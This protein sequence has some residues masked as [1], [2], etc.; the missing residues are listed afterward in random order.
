MRSQRSLLLVVAIT[1]G[2]GAVALFLLD[3]GSQGSIP[4]AAPDESGADSLDPAASASASAQRSRRLAAEP[5]LADNATSGTGAV[6]DVRS[7]AVTSSPLVRGVVSDGAGRPVPGATVRLVSLVPDG[8]R[9]IDFVTWADEQGRFSFVRQPFL[10]RMANEGGLGL[11][12]RGAFESA[13]TTPF[14]LGGD[15]VVTVAPVRTIVGRLRAS[16]GGAVYRLEVRC[17][18]AGEGSAGHHATVEVEEDG[19][20]ELTIPPGRWDLEVAQRFRNG[21][22]TIDR[23]AAVEVT[24]RGA[25]EPSLEPW[26]LPGR[27]KEVAVVAADP[28][29]SVSGDAYFEF[30]D[31]AML[32]SSLGDT[33]LVYD[34]Y[35]LE[36]LI[37]DPVRTCGSARI[38]EGPV[39]GPEI[40]LPTPGTVDLVLSGEHPELVGHR[41]T[42]RV[43]VEQPAPLRRGTDF[44][45]LELDELPGACDRIEVPTIGTITVQFTV[46]MDEIFMELSERFVHELDPWQTH[47]TLEHELRITKED[48]TYLAEI[49]A[50]IERERAEWEALQDR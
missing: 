42:A 27:F 18:A 14:E 4:S 34:R 40:L 31:G 13:R 19:R 7:P 46:E 50:Q 30:T 41:I 24:A 20:F 45:A 32:R 44:F 38:L 10:V 21:S 37:V 49:R 48:E 12:A 15:V 9:R 28:D 47:Q 33:L 11:V 25:P 5:S 26:T 16:D 29:A 23:R 8:G 1:L 22:R 3:P 6:A 43:Q 35:E 39:F 36:R 17:Y 2:L